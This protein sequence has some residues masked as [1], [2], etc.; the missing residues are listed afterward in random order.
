M[1]R[2]SIFA[3]VVFC[4]AMSAGCSS[5]VMA[6]LEKIPDGECCIEVSDEC[7]TVRVCGTKET[8]VRAEEP[9]PVE[10]MEPLC[11]NLVEEAEGSQPGVS[12]AEPLGQTDIT[13]VERFAEKFGFPAAMAIFLAVLLWKKLTGIEVKLERLINVLTSKGGS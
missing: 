4:L 5:T 7:K 6:F 1:V 10:C 12:P 11:F 13:F 3:A 9:E 8:K 2:N